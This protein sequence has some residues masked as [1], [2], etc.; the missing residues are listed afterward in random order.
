MPD[1]ALTV[2]LKVAPDT[3]EVRIIG[4]LLVPEQMVWLVGLGVT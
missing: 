2:Q 3:S 1:G 4:A